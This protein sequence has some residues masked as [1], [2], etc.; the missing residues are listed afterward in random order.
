[1]KHQEDSDLDRGLRAAYEPEPE[2][3]HRVVA[4]AL[5]QRS[6]K[7]A[8]RRMAVVL[9]SATLLLACFVIFRNISPVPPE[10]FQLEYVGGVAVLEGP[11]GSSW[12]VTPDTA[13]EGA[14][15]GLNLILVGGDQP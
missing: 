11:D 5:A 2:A 9:A 13:A 8:S 6:R 10:T 15:A 4:G 7:P 1:M 3:V 14:S 12:L